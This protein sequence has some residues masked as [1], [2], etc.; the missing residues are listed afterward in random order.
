MSV[1]GFATIDNVVLIN[2]EVRKIVH[3]RAGGMEGVEG[4]EDCSGDPGHD[5]AI[6]FPFPLPCFSLIRS[7]CPGIASAH[8]PPFC[9]SLHTLL[10]TFFAGHWH[11]RRARHCV[12]HLLDSPRC[13]HQRGHD[14]PGVDLGVDLG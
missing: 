2:V 6:A 7:A 9:S 11:G 10:H 3:V 14:Q 5:A 4:Q 1:K 8:P 12:G 13:Q